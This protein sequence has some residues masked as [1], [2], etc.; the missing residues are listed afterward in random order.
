MRKIIETYRKG[1]LFAVPFVNKRGETKYRV[2]H[3]EGY[4]R[5]TDYGTIQSDNLPY[6]F[7]TS[8]SSLIE[9]LITKTCELCGKHGNVV[10]HHVRTLK[11]LKG[12]NDRERKM[13]YMHRKTLVVCT[14]YNTKI[15]NCDK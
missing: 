11:E 6:T 13:F 3:N 8:L 7:K 1:N 15:Q 10:M 9:R 2:F 14:E 5:K 4:V 12:K